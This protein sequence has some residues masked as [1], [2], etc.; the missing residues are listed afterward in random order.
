MSLPILAFAPQSGKFGKWKDRWDK[1][2]NYYGKAQEVGK[3]LKAFEKGAEG[4]ENYAKGR[5]FDESMA[6]FDALNKGNSKF[7][8]A[9]DLFKNFN[10]Q[11]LEDD[12]AKPKKINPG[13]YKFRPG[14]G[15]VQPLSLGN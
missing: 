9:S 15:D 6:V 3:A 4:V 2:S 7:K 1:A 8:E 13:K 10:K 14:R 11:F 12:N 5:G